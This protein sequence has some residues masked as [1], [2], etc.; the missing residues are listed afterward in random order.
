MLSLHTGLPVLGPCL[1]YSEGLGKKNHFVL[2][3]DYTPLEEYITLLQYRTSIIDSYAR[4]LGIYNP[5]FKSLNIEHPDADFKEV[6]NKH[7]PRTRL[8][9]I[10]LLLCSYRRQ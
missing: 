5:L 8:S 6:E 2:D 3:M 7:V 10:G 9:C 4:E 1:C